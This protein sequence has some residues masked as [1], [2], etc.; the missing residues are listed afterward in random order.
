MV[1]SRWGR[2]GLYAGVT[3]AVVGFSKTHAVVH[4]YS[5]SG[6]SRFTW[7]I[8]YSALLCL[9]AYAFG[10]PD[11]TTS[12]RRA[13]AAGLAATASAALAV[14]AVQFFVG[15]DY[16]PRFV[17]LGVA[18]VLVPWYVLC[19]AL[20]LDSRA[21]VGERDRVV[22]VAS[23]DEIDGLLSE[24]RATPE[25]PAVV[26]MT[27]VTDDARST[28]LPPTRPLVDG[29]H[30]AHATV[31]VLSRGAQDV[32]DIVMQA[33][34]LHQEG[35]RV[36]T[37]SMFYE[38]W[39]GK[40]PIGELERITL[41]FDIGEIHAARYARV[42]RLL[43]VGAAGVGLVALALI[44][45]LVALADCIGNR[46]PLVFRQ[47]RIGRNGAT[48]EILKFRTMRPVAELEIGEW[49][50]DQDP[51]IT[52]FGRLLRR[53]HLDELPQVINILR[54]DLSIVGPRPEQPR[55]VAEL[56]EK[57]PF[58]GVRHL[59]R[60]GLTGWAQVKYSYGATVADALEKLQYDVYYLLRQSIGLDVRIIFRTLRSVLYGEGR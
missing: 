59:V 32:D 50:T 21:R 9:T 3:V 40:L 57:I 43:D 28:S 30:A 17:V 23:A 14:S 46:G 53:T 47:A 48:F 45:P 42:K 54:G 36:R 24:L 37:L 39:L 26:V 12:R 55:Y 60:P 19:S 49:T 6:S 7:S 13:W 35:T 27:L 34:E 41:L 20:T 11:L 29:A 58:Y 1:V 2:I 56:S 25:R 31:L 15:D 33:A 16:L 5:W 38:Q 22:V 52:P 18:V 44:A 10:L 4:Q 51:R 8:A